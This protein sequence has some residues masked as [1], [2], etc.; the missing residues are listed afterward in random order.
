MKYVFNFLIIIFYLFFSISVFADW[1]EEHLKKAISLNGYKLPKEIN[2]NFNTKKAELGKF[3][4]ENSL[5]SFNS[6]TNCQSCHLDTA[7]SADGLPNAIGVGGKGEGLERLKSNGMIV[8]RNT[9]P[10]WGRGGYEF[11]A[12]FWDGKV[13]K[14]GSKVISQFGSDFPSDDLLTVA[15]HLP[16]V[17]IRE[18]ITDSDIIREKYKKENLNAAKQIQE[19]LVNRVKNRDELL[20]RYLEAYDIKKLNLKFIHIADSVSHHIRNK[21]RLRDTKFSKFFENK[22]Q[23]T[24]DEIEGG[25]IFYGKGKCSICHNGPHFSD[26]D[27][28]RIITPQLGFG[29]NGF[30]IDYGRFNVTFDYDDLYKFR[31]PPLANVEKTKPYGHSGSL[32]TLKE[33]IISHY[34]PLSLI[35]MK[36]L[37]P[38]RRRELFKRISAI[39]NIENIPSYLDDKELNYLQSFLK[40]LTF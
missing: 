15:V 35:D 8:P 25:L 17:E 31:T 11:D 33:M 14:K 28:H 34:D 5:L 29:R 20:F 30:G 12:F 39:E 19:E 1:K 13:T 22:V 10:L 40:T 23:L 36:N 18:M 6:N 37:D 26:F 3:I 16:F 4:F 2:K 38:I 24:N 32:N 9:L 7:S 21:F 27:Y